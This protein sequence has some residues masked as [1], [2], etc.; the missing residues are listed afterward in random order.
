VPGVVRRLITVALALVA[1]P[2]PTGPYAVGRANYIWVND[3][4]TDALSPRGSEKETVV[5]W[6]WYPAVRDAQSRRADYLPKPWQAALARHSGKLLTFLA[7]DSDRVQVHST[8]GPAVSAAHPSYPVAIM[9]AGGAGLTTDYTILAEDL[10]SHGYFV[11]GMD[12]PY[13]TTVFVWPNG[14][15]IERVPSANLD[16]VDDAG[17]RR[18]AE[19]LLPMW[20]GD[21]HFALDR[22][23]ALNADDPS[24]RFTGRLD[25][26]RL[27]IFGHSFGGAQALQFCHEDL[28]CRA[29]IDIDGIAFGSVVQQGLDKPGLILM[30]DHSREMSDPE[31][32]EIISTLESVY[33]RFPTGLFV[34]IRGAN[35]FS[36]S[37]QILLRSHLLISALMAVHIFG[38]LQPRRG[39]AIVAD[40]VHTFFDVYLNGTPPA[41]L[42]NLA[43]KYPEV[44]AESH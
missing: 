34:T 42:A 33:R 16:L 44:E 25:F 43:A 20:T 1:L 10:A 38:D 23:E 13:R 22:L 15:V 3:N 35:H 8:L 4:V 2:T 7:R 5:V 40:Y 24:G 39:L 11:V 37:D 26:S 31:S 27:G 12:A 29:A 19:E 14:R 18:I 36:F 32:E 28:R 17:A 41:Q 6:I 30:S 21:I 9:R